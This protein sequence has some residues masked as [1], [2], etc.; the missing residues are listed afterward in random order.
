M[1]SKRVPQT[2]TPHKGW[3]TESPLKYWFY[4]V[5]VYAGVRADR[6]LHHQ[7]PCHQDDVWALWAGPQDLPEPPGK[8]PGEEH[9]S[10]QRIWQRPR[11][12]VQKGRG[13]ALAPCGLHRRTLPWGESTMFSYKSCKNGLSETRSVSYIMFKF[14]AVYLSWNVMS[15]CKN[16]S[17]CCLWTICFKKTIQHGL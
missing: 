3:I 11:G 5:R 13:G 14:K 2:R 7:L 17:L 12:A 16:I 10:E 9:R 6:D 8:I 1:S 4:P 15:H